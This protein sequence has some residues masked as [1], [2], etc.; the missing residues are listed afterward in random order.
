MLSEPKTASP[1]TLVRRSCTSWALDRRADQRAAHAAGRLAPEAAR[2]RRPR[3]GG[4]VAGPE[5]ASWGRRRCGRR[6]PAGGGRR[7]RSGRRAGGRP[8]PR[9]RRPPGDPARAPSPSL[10]H[11]SVARSSRPTPRGWRAGARVRLGLAQDLVRHRR[12]VA[13]AEQDVADQVLE[14]VAL[15]P[16]EVGVR[17]LPGRVAQ[18]QQEGG[19]RVRDRP[20]PRPAAPGSRRPPRP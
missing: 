16:A 5:L 6:T 13:L 3:R 14:R 18:V 12:D 15:G 19:D 1:L 7:G 9:A 20:R 10:A 2:R 8:P 11:S 17:D 4:E